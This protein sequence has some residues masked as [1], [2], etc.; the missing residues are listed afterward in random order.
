MKDKILILIIGILIGAILATG[1]CLIYAKVN[2]N[3]NKKNINYGSGMMRNSEMPEIPEMSDNGQRPEKSGNGED[4]LPK[5][6]DN[7]KK[8]K[9][10]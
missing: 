7:N 3:K 8:S 2:N 9:T 5:L 6:E 10:I 1:G 4:M